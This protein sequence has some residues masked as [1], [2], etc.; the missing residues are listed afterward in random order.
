MTVYYF[1]GP[2]ARP[3]LRNGGPA[4]VYAQDPLFTELDVAFLASLEIV[5]VEAPAATALVTPSTFVYAPHCE[6]CFFLPAMQGTDAALII[7]NALESVADGCV[8][9][10]PDAVYDHPA[11]M[12]I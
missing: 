4:K 5:V 3:G 10:L 6:R 8:A 9:H 12:T 11:Q 2:H 7:C 1:E